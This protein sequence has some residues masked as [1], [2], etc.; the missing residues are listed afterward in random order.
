ML[1][2]KASF[3]LSPALAHQESLHYLPLQSHLLFHPHKLVPDQAALRSTALLPAHVLPQIVR[4][5]FAAVVMSDKAFARTAV[6][7]RILAVLAYS[8]LVREQRIADPVRT[9]VALNSHTE[10][11]QL[12]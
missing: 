3:L 5:Q 9:A 4:A 11:A 2:S 12:H 1:P 7:Q 6:P 10:L 8:L